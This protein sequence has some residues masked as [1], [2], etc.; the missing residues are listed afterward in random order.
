[1]RHL[2]TLT[3][4]LVPLFFVSLLWSQDL[5]EAAKKEKE[6]REALKGKKVTVISNADLSDV[7]KKPAVG[8]ENPSTAAE[9][10]AGQAQP[11]EPQDT[12]EAG[13]PEETA[14]ETEPEAA[15]EGAP[16]AMP[17]SAGDQLETAAPSAA[18][19]SQKSMLETAWLKAQE[20]ADLLE[21]KL[22]SLWQEFYSMDDMMPRDKL[23][24]QISDTFDKYQKAREDEA[25][26]K[27]EFD[28]YSS[29]VRK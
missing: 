9:P 17:M 3:F 19:N 2:K 26:A 18:L 24:E 20:Y 5:T 16:E 11:A 21:L 10:E 13:T 14:A 8:G 1:M 22:N 4:G 12:E 25:K 27:E 23:Q 15:V 28:K 6:R 7:K 29:V